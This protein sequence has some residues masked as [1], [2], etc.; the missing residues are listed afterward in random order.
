MYNVPRV[1]PPLLGTLIAHMSGLLVIRG[2]AATRPID[3]ASAYGA[4]PSGFLRLSVGVGPRGARP[5]R[6][7][8]VCTHLKFESRCSYDHIVNE[9]NNENDKTGVF[10]ANLNSS[11]KILEIV[12]MHNIL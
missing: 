7:L 6:I 11:C 4:I 8:H 3:V 2:A 10:N 9:S 1:H 12:A 5:T